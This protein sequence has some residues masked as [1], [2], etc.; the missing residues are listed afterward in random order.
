MPKLFLLSLIVGF[1]IPAFAAKDAPVARVTVAQLEQALTTAHDRPDAEVAQQL[2][3]MELTERLSTAKLT[4]L[5]AY[6]PGSKA[7]EALVILADSAA[8][9]NPPVTEI[10]ADAA[11]DP[12]AAR[13]MLTGIVN[14]VNSTV[15]QLPNLM[16]ERDT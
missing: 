11:P 4:H 2:S 7:Q 5:K 10:L 6:L 15:R 8:F 16:A 3:G 12:A 14:Y 13:Q 1:A 9:L